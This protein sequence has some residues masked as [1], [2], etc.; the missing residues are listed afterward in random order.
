PPSPPPTIRADTT[1][2]FGVGVN[3][4]ASSW[5]FGDGPVTSGN[6]TNGAVTIAG[7]NTDLREGWCH[8]HQAMITSATGVSRYQAWLMQTDSNASVTA[9]RTLE[10]EPIIT[11]SA[12]SRASVATS[13]AK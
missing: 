3:P 7:S 9:T 2:S 4:T 5:R 11:H 6:T 1:I 13:C 10:G 12:T 8:H